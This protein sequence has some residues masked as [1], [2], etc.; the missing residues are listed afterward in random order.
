M[1]YGCISLIPGVHLFMIFFTQTVKLQN[2]AAVSSKGTGE[3]TLEGNVAK[4][5][6]KVMM[7]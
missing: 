2:T 7:T 5:I 3:E 6:Q 1:G 4:G